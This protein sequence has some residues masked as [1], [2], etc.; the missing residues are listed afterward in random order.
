MF[1]AI[2]M[3]VDG[4]GIVNSET[5]KMRLVSY[6]ELYEMLLTEKHVGNVEVHYC[7]ADSDPEKVLDLSEESLRRHGGVRCE[8]GCSSFTKYVG[9]NEPIPIR[10][11][12][13]ESVDFSVE[14]EKVIIVSGDASC[15]FWYDGYAY[16]VKREE[17]IGLYFED[18]R[19][20]MVAEDCGDVAHIPISDY[21]NYSN[22]I[23]CERKDFLRTIL[24]K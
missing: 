21:K 19:G 7:W 6:E 15:Y 8:F 12:V 16:E 10:V 24:F 22:P 5:L 2:G 20:F 23:R 3:G 4:V 14:H 13:D 11:D 17:L 9:E 18:E 1:Y